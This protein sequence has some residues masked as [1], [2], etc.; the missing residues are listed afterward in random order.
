MKVNT[1]RNSPEISGGGQVIDENP[2]AA[3]KF[4]FTNRT[5]EDRSP[6]RVLFDSD[7]VHCATRTVARGGR[8]E[9][10]PFRSPKFDYSNLV[11][12]LGAIWLLP[13]GEVRTAESTGYGHWHMP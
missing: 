11:A 3:D 13:R 7:F 6:L 4:P 5:R 8:T 10:Y 12:I 1:C 9:R 2:N